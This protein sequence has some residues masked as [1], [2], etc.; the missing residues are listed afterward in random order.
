VI[1]QTLNRQ[2]MLDVLPEAEDSHA[3]YAW[4]G[5]PATGLQV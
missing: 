2:F 5:D 1:A 3:A 4:Y